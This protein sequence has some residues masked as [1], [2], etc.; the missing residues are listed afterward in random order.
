MTTPNSIVPALELAFTPPTDGTDET[1]DTL[2][3][4]PEDAHAIVT[5]LSYLDERDIDW[6][7]VG[8]LAEIMKAG[9]WM[10][11]NPLSFVISTTGEPQLVDG[12]HQ[13]HAVIVAGFIEKWM[14]R[15]YWNQRFS[16]DFLYQTMNS[17]RIARD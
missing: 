11:L 16:G 15:C 4:T 14:V 9:N 12:H 13:L 8:V 5:H 6:V 10:P 17:L 2:M 1:W 3:L 7:H